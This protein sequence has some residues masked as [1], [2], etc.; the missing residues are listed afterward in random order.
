MLT[1][2]ENQLREQ[3]AG[4]RLDEV[5]EEIPRVREDLGYIPLVTPTSQIVGTQAV[6]NVLTGERYKTVTK[7]TS[8]VLRGEYG[9]TP[10][11]V[12]AELQHRVLPEGEGPITCRPADNLAPEMESLTAELEQIARE[13]TIPLAR[14]E[15]DDVLIYALFPQI[16]LKFLENRNNPSAFEPPPWEEGAAPAPAPQAAAMPVQPASEAYRIEVNG[17]AYEVTVSPQGTV[18][19]VAAAAPPPPVP[20]APPAGTATTL[21]APLAGN[22]FKLKVAQGQR[23]QSGDVVLLLE[24]MKMETE[25]RAP[26]AGVV[27]EIRVKEGDSVHVGD[28]LLVLA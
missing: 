19:T 28:P 4:A 27:A 10:A 16:G 17:K 22:I 5:L 23:V 24:A 8:G 25:V 11:P 14:D 18:Q 21:A 20:A 1:N 2:M 3:G 13:K 7:E 12:N 6:L 26:V 15:V 9:V